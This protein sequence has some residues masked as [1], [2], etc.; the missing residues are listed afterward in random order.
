[1]L[2]VDSRSR[3]GDVRSALLTAPGDPSVADLVRS[4]RLVLWISVESDHPV[5]GG[6]T[7][8]LKIEAK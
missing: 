2:P 8:P 1:M 6:D 4:H 7:F 3:G 5:V